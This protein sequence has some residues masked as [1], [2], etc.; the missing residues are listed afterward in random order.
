MAIS[1]PINK[2]HPPTTDAPKDDDHLRTEIAQAILALLEAM[3]NVESDIGSNSELFA[4]LREVFLYD[5]ALV[6]ESRDDDLECTAS[7]PG[8]FTAGAGSRVLCKTS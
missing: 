4:A 8:E 7:V 1:A 2:T 6:L 3:L 5:Q